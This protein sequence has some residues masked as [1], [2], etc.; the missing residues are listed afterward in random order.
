MT[1]PTREDLLGIVVDKLPVRSV[2]SCRSCTHRVARWHCSRVGYQCKT[3]VQYGG[4][5]AKGGI[6]MLYVKKTLI[7]SK[8]FEWLI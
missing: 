4:E 8:L 2:I 1:E 3:E 6:M 7:I 5:C